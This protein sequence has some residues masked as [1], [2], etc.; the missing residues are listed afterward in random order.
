MIKTAITA[1]KEAGEVIKKTFGNVPWTRHK[2]ANDFVTHTDEKCEALIIKMIRDNFP[3][4][5]ILS[6]ECGDD[7]KISD[8][9]W[10][11]DPLDGTNNFVYNIPLVCTSIAM[12]YKGEVV[13]GVINVPM[14]N[15]LIYAEKGKGTFLNG[16]QVRVKERALKD[17][18]VYLECGDMHSVD[19]KLTSFMLALKGEIMG[20]RITG[21]MSYGFFLDATSSFNV[22]FIPRTTP[23]DIAAGGLIV[24]ETGAIVTEIS[25]KKWHP[26][27]KDILISCKTNHKALA[28]ILK[29]AGY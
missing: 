23:W 28:K 25:G 12:A 20:M 13:L 7:N 14:L 21:S 5:S 10:I 27:S 9:K 4:H 2:S 24:E 3:G 18:F 15:H 22:H 11:I 17:S 26:Y 16:K 6:E 19:K 1:A 29:K 8:Y